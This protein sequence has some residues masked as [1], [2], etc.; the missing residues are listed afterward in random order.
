MSASCLGR[1]HDQR[2]LN[3]LFELA[4]LQK[5]YH[6]DASAVP[7]A[8]REMLPDELISHFSETTQLLNSLSGLSQK[9]PGLPLRQDIFGSNMLPAENESSPCTSTLSS[10]PPSLS[11]SPCL[12]PGSPL[13]SAFPP[14]PDMLGPS[15]SS[16]PTQVR[17][18]SPRTSSSRAPSDQSPT[19]SP[20]KGSSICPAKPKRRKRAKNPVS[21]YCHV[22]GT[23]ETSEWRRGPD[24]CKSLCNACGL[25]YA[26]IVKKEQMI[27]PNPSV[28]FSIQTLLN[29]A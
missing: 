12:P 24:N 6:I 4:M 27:P 23:K 13:G 22:C 1:T 20:K 18:S 15:T 3:F 5:A 14:M 19:V 26:K 17:A 2:H 8:E 11:S 10:S 28:S 16:A 29:P 25:H 9:R 7:D 21:F